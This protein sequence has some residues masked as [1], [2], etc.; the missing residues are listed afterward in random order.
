MI[1]CIRFRSALPFDENVKEEFVTII[2]DDVTDRWGG[3]FHARYRG[4]N[5]NGTGHLRAG[6]WV[7]GIPLFRVAC[8]H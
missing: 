8:G 3:R 7:Y 4:S 1:E 6:G 2:W 5:T